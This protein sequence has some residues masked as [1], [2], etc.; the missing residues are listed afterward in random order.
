MVAD[1]EVS[2]WKYVLSGVLQ[3]SILGSIIFLI[4]IN[5]LEEWITSRIV[6]YGD[7]TK[8]FRKIEGNCD[9]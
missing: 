6:K 7:D 5:G 1:D 9:K 3:G 2:N 8:L 4:Q